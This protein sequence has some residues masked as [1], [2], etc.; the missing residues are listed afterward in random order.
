MYEDIVLNSPFVF[1][2]FSIL[3]YVKDSTFVATKLS[4]E[5]KRQWTIAVRDTVDPDYE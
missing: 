5:E 2:I 1:Q 3:L 4:T